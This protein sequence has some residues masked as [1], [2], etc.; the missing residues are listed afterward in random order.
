MNR[1]NGVCWLCHPILGF[2]NFDIDNM[3]NM[4][5]SQK[6]KSHSQM[7]VNKVSLVL[8]GHLFAKSSVADSLV[9]NTI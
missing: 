1:M 2:F 9:I 5:Y 6:Q 8:L 3:M 7:C 4:L